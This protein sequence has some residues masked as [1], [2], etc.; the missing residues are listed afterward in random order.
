MPRQPGGIPEE[1]DMTGNI[2]QLLGR[3]PSTMSENEPHD[4]IIAWFEVQSEATKVKFIGSLI[5]IGDDQDVEVPPE[6]E[7]VLDDWCADHPQYQWRSGR[8]VAK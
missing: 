2:D 4:L 7:K 5:D 3:D 6:I 1:R 8:I